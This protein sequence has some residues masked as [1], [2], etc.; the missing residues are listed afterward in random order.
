MQN[1]W[2]YCCGL[3]GE[4]GYSQPSVQ[5]HNIEGQLDRSLTLKCSNP[6]LEL[7]DDET[8]LYSRSETKA[9]G[10]ESLVPVISVS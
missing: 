7:R 8:P 3:N 10:L 1:S 9:F 2:P 5:I 4:A 6:S